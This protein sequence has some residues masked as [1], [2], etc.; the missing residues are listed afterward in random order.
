MAEPVNQIDRQS[1]FGRV[2]LLA[3]AIFERAKPLCDA[4]LPG[5]HAV[6]E[7]FVRRAVRQCLPQRNIFDSEVES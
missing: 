4:N 2:D 6:F 7:P 1:P 5:A 3:L